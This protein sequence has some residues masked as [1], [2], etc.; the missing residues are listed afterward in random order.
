M[1]K[2][3][4]ANKNYSSW[5]LRPWVLMKMLGIAFEEQLL[6]FEADS[7]EKFRAVSP[8]GTVPC[9]HDGDL[10]IWDSM[11]IAEYLAERHDGVWPKDAT[12]RAFA[13]SAASEMHGGFT[14]LR[15]LCTMNCGI[16]AK[17]RQE[18]PQL[19]RNVDRIAE[20]WA[21]GLGRFGGPFLAGNDFTAVDAFFAPVAFRIQ[22]Y[23]LSMPSPAADYAARLLAL[24]AMKEW[25][26]A[27]LAETFRE[28]GH[29]VE[30]AAIAE[31]IEDLRAS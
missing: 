25:Y 16:R 27:A 18:T 26:E 2:L 22:T 6:R 10:K 17:V 12:A 30:L 11:A 7:W 19:R 28:P 5:S 15:S 23:G 21:E 24:P 31:I 3:F 8:S 29:E 20:L 9:L 14:A 13:R 4:I 1:L